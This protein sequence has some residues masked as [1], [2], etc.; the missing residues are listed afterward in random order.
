MTTP[1]KSYIAYRKSWPLKFVVIAAL[2]TALLI[3]AEDQTEP[4][5]TGMIGGLFFDPDH[6]Y[7]AESSVH[8]PL[9][10]DGPF[11][12]SYRQHEVTPVFKENSQTQL[13]NTQNRIQGDYMLNEYLRVIGLGGYQRTAFE[14]RAGW[15]DAWQAGAGVGSP[16]L[17]APTRLEWSVT[18]GGFPA[19]KNL[20]ADWWADVHVYWRAY[21]F[22]SGKMLET[23]YHPWL[24]LGMDIESANEGSRFHAL[25]R[26]G[27][28]LE[29]ESANGNR[30]RF[31]VQWFANDGNPF[32]EENY[33][34]MLVGMEVISSFDKDTLYDA[35]ELRRPGWLPLV[36]GQYDVGYG[37]D[38]AIQRTELNV[39]IHDFM[40]GEQAITALLWYESRQEYQ[41]GDFD[42]VA[43][44]IS[45]GAQT[46]VG[47][48][49]IMSQGQPLVVGAEY[50]HRSAH[51]LAPD[52]SRVPPPTVLPHDSLNL[53]RVR[54]QTLGWDLPYRDPS[55]Y[56]PK[57]EWLN[58]FDWRVT[59][60]YDF[61][62]S[63][64]RG[65]PAAQAGLNWD[66]A[67]VRGCVVYG[68][69]IGSVGNETPDWL[70]EVGVRRRAW[71]LFFRAE[72]YGLEDDL[73]RGNTYVMGIGF[74]L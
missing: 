31:R 29:I 6:S 1:R 20:D 67:T 45:F 48:E 71:T 73:A 59:L 10:R 23:E 12:L 25:Y 68:R 5:I 4:V 39:E 18:A 64:D 15:L 49:S 13:L 63:R 62:H 28:I 26:I 52:A 60:G 19:R 14:D 22:K 66:V 9:F 65:N 3:R 17:P 53:A 2:S 11:M 33:S 54:L 44:S 47:L 55:I 69:G 21:E 46:R 51:A 61:H 74:R 43:Y 41:N 16:I 40:L 35:R 32:Y 42:N 56:D 72:S 70:G 37:N 27:P 57:T 24:G 38:R 58:R 30:A 50:L 7:M 34:S 36:W 8:L